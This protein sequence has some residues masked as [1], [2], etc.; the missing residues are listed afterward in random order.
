MDKG[1]YLDSWKDIAA[2]LGRNIRTCR[3]WE[4]DLGLPVHRLDDSPKSHVFAY[5]DEIDA[6]REM[7]GRLSENE[8]NGGDGKEAANRPMPPQTVPIR[9][10]V[11]AWAVA[12]LLAG[13]LL[14]IIAT[15]LITR[16]L[17]PTGMSAVSRSIIKIEPG[18][19]LESKR[20]LSGS[21]RPTR[22]AMA[23]SGDGRFVVYSAIEANPSPQAQPWLFLRR[24]DESEARRIAGTE[25]GINPFLAP[26]DRW[27][28]FWADGKLKKVPVEGGVPITLCELSPWFYGASWGRDGIVFSD[29]YDAGLSVVSAAGGKPQV[30][31]KPDPKREEYSHRLPSWLPNRK[32]VLVTVMRH[33]WDAH[34]WLGLLRLD[35]REWRVLLQD[36][37]DA[38]YVPTGHLVFLRQ[39]TLMAVRFDL[40]R[41]ELIGQPAEIVESVMQAFSTGSWFHTG[42][43]QFSTSDT[44]S[45][46]YAA[47]GIL[48]DTKDSLVWVDQKG[49]EQPITA[50]Q[51]PF[52]APRLSPD[53][54]RI[55]CV[56]GR[57]S[58]VFV[59]ELAKGTN[60]PL[61]VEGFAGIPI[62]SP[63]GKRLLFPWMKSLVWNLFWQPYDGSSPMERLT[64][65]E[66]F[67]VPASWHSDGKTVAV[68]EL[69]SDA[70]FDI[71]LLDVPS[72]RVTPFLDSRSNELFPDFSPDGRWIAYTSDESKRNEVYV[73]AFPGPGLKQPVSSQGGEEPL[74]ARNGK[75]LFYTWEDQ[76][77]VVDVKTDD[78]FAAAKPRLL[79]K[80]PGYVGG[81]PVRT[82]D[83]SLDGQRF[84]MGK[85]ARWK[86]IPVTEMILVQNW[87]EELKRIVPTDK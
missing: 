32:A 71:V 24:M 39:G 59:Y 64:T 66:Y 82:Y 83:L 53:G 61:T 29:T 74:W 70:N 25:G 44:G 46:I 9:R 36:A 75:Q 27:V 78:D 55:A 16:H 63:D 41:M 3:N 34:P 80:I 19:W 51:F 15:V 65:N 50:L 8:E 6:W 21:E 30:L 13:P 62:W 84:L 5:T 28:G 37:A 1:K 31:T 47:G 76:V 52:Y 7:K 81:Y 38:R 14:A 69:R 26:D 67:Q 33:A 43:G 68:V 85:P 2:Y 42:A 79:F 35:T 40:A 12:A 58:Q 18:H 60:S 77:W 4:R 73:R 86:P 20:E 54:Q 23:I 72:G 87:F 45:L 10:S 56:G 57:D 17:R 49:T 48:P 22:T 11:R